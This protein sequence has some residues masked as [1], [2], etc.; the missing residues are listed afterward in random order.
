MSEQLLIKLSKLQIA[1]E[2]AAIYYDSSLLLTV[3]TQPFTLP[4]SPGKFIAKLS[5]AQA[6]VLLAGFVSLIST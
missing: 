3:R 4:A 2:I 6:S 1:H 5:Q